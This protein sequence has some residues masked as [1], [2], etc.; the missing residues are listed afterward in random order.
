MTVEVH[1]ETSRLCCDGVPV[2]PPGLEIR[3]VV[4]VDGGPEADAILVR[5]SSDPLDVD[6]LRITREGGVE[7]L[8]EG[9][10]VH[11]AAVG[12]GIVVVSATNQH[13]TTTV[14]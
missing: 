13:G 11:G 4:G 3:S 9:Q 7:N 8:T 12:G 2:S 6:V 5:A 1:G 10:G 14:T